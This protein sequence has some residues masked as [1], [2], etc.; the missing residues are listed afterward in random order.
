MGYV[1][2]LRY[3]VFTLHQRSA[4]HVIGVSVLPCD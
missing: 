4:V 3:Y 1:Y 2:V